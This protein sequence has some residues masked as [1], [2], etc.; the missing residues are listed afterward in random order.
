M[1]LYFLLSYEL[2]R[3]GL[4]PRFPK[5]MPA[6]IVSP[7]SVPCSYVFVVLACLFSLVFLFK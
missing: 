3:N 7:S 1:R 5:D 4:F 2:L 6:L